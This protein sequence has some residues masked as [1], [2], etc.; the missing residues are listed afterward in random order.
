[1]IAT[2]P[3]Y[4]SDLKLT[5]I[6]ATSDLTIIAIIGTQRKTLLQLKAILLTALYI[7]YT[8]SK[9]IKERKF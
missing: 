1:M 7:L 3:K 6:I 4:F 5:A 9:E 2:K 8:S